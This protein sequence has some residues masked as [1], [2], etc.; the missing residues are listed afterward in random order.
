[1]IRP[2]PHPIYDLSVDGRNVTATL[3][4]RL[5]SLTLTDNRGFEA[6]QLDIVLDDTDGRLDLPPRGAEIRAAIGWEDT[7]LED[8]GSYTV[9]EIEHSGAPDLLTIRARSAD[10]RGGLSTQMERSF[11]GKTV[12]DIVRTVAAENDLV[13]VVDARLAAQVIEHIDQTNESSANLLTRM[14]GMFDAI[15]TVKA[16]R[17]LFL[18]TGSAASASGT[19]LERVVITRQDGDSHRFSLADRETYTAV[20]ANWHD[21]EHATKGEVIWGKEEDEVERNRRPA[22]QPSAGAAQYRSVG[23]T[24]KSRAR[25]HRLAVK[26]WKRLSKSAAFRAQYAGVRVAYDDRVLGT[27]GEVTYGA[28]DM[29]KAKQNAA[30]Q[31]RRDAERLA[32]ARPESA[33]DHS[34]D[35]IK[36]LRHVYANKTNAMRA[37]RA[38]WRRLQRGMAAFSITLAR[39]RADLSPEVPATVTGWKPSIDNTDWL[40]VR[41]THNLNDSGYTT[42]LEL[43]IRATE[44]PG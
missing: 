21:T 44:I 22:P 7:G 38:E 31:A 6:D 36:T 33:F 29:E 19:P 42:T 39:G 13:P 3:K 11:H 16:G 1:V 41:V 5:G 28:A 17:L 12:G 23:T 27:Q 18:A 37:A 26:E 9:D 15:A 8:K 35:N 32:G 30:R 10:L 25:A 2:H 34:A 43:E 20:R 24:Q 14:A 40:I 4:G